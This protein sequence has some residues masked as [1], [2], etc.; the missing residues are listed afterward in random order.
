MLE[1]HEEK[2]EE[3]ED[4]RGS[5]TYIKDVKKQIRRLKK[6][7]KKA[8]KITKPPDTNIVIIG[9][10]YDEILKFIEHLEVK[11]CLT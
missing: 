8:G 10:L 2:E 3:K 4:G 7:K 5:I 1:N 6:G 9:K 11:G